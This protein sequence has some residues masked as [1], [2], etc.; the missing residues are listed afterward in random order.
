MACL[1]VQGLN[2]EGVQGSASVSRCLKAC[3]RVLRLWTQASS[4]VEILRFGAQ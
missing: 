4:D 3:L 2:A 1:W